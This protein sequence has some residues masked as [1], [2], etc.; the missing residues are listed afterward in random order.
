MIENE[1]EI[2]EVRKFSHNSWI[3]V[4]KQGRLLWVGYTSAQVDGELMPDGKK[5]KPLALKITAK[6]D[7]DGTCYLRIE[8]SDAAVKAEPVIV[9]PAEVP[10][11]A[12]VDVIEKLHEAVEKDQMERIKELKS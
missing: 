11:V 5:I 12:P 9:K 4:W 2:A 1:V 7:A 10:K 8:K 3:G 6:K